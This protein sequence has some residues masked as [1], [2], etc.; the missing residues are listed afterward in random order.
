MSCSS[1]S[2]KA[3]ICWSASALRGA[4]AVVNVGTWHAAHLAWRNTVAPRRTVGR[5]QVAAGRHRR[6]LHEQ[7]Q[8]LQ[9][10]LPDF[11]CAT[12]RLGQAG[13]L[14][15]RAARCG[16]VGTGDALFRV[17]GRD[18]LCTDV[19]LVRFPPESAEVTA[20]ICAYDPVRAAG[21]AI[22]VMILGVGQ[23]QD[24]RLGHR[25]EQTHADHWRRHAWRKPRAA[26]QW[27]VGQSR[28]SCGA[29]C[30]IV[31]SVPST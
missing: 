28:Q 11:R 3:W 29:V 16:K 4:S 1:R 17:E 8:G 7:Q 5:C 22:A 2:V 21:D 13:R 19:R 10:L 12:V 18:R 24:A 31:H 14:H 23:R 27:P 30:R 9:V 25:L 6:S 26:V 20:T 15:G